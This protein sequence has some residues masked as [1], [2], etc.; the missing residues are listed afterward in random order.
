M[1]FSLIYLPPARREPAVAKLAE[2]EYAGRQAEG[3]QGCLSEQSQSV[4]V[5]DPFGPDLGTEPLAGSLSTRQH[6]AGLAQQL[7]GEKVYVYCFPC[8]C[9]THKGSR[10]EAVTQGGYL[11]LGKLDGVRE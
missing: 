2:G 4:I 11:C 7:S 5:A 9:Q 1:S 10:E 3:L 8:G 6:A